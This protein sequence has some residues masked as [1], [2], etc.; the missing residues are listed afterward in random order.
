MN[1]IA[2]GGSFVSFPALVLAGLPSVTANAS[3]TVALFPG[4]VTS[5]W[6]L[7]RDLGQVGRLPFRTL[8]AVSAVGG[9]LGAILLLTTPARTFDAVLPWLLLLATV[10]YAAGL[11]I[12]RVTG[13][14]E[15]GNGVVLAVQFVVALYAGYFGGAAGILMMAGWA[16][17]TTTRLSVLNPARSVCVNAANAT[18]VLCFVASGRVAWPAT[19]AMMAGAIAGGYL[20]ARIAR[21]VRPQA[22]RIATIALSALVTAAF[23]V[24]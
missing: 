23:F 1:A 22:L 4:G 2:G 5:A 8:L 20:G 15:A 16:L 14:A 24:R 11:Q 19:L 6:A 21:A 17:L 18:A 9:L 10:A 12:R 13:L 7:R 3:S